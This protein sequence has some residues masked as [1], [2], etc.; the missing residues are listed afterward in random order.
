M[1]K[2]LLASLLLALCG[3]ASAG[4]T[5]TIAY[6]FGPADTEA[7][8][9]RALIAEANRAQDKYNFVFDIKPGAGNSIAANY[10]LRTPNT[11]LATS[12]AFFVRPNLFPNESYPI[13]EFKELLPLAEDPMGVASG[14][15]K[16]WQEVP[17]DS[18]ITVGISGLGVTT[19]VIVMQLATKYPKLKVVPY[20]STT[21]ANLALVAGQLDLQIGFLGEEL[22]WVNNSDITKRVNIL[23]LTGTKVVNGYAT[24]VSQGFPKTLAQMNIPEHLVV[25]ANVPDDKF[26]E[27]RGILFKAATA[28]SVQETFQQNFA[29]PLNQM[30]D[31][32]IQ[33]WYAKQT[34]HWKQVSSTIKLD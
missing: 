32:S 4:E 26:A 22:P 11:I 31:N 30:S 15:F 16:T 23:G 17:T 7:Q 8:T 13:S 25:A 24:L 18:Q 6:G 21:E 34:D 27:W 9:V 10:A 3:V 33:P 2:K 20:K 14:K 19:H 28:A 5:V 1:I 12:S 29:M